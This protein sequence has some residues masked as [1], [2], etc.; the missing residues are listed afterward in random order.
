MPRGEEQTCRNAPTA[1]LV[2]DVDHQVIALVTIAVLK[3]K[4]S[5]IPQRAASPLG[6]RTAPPQQHTGH[7]HHIWKNITQTP[8]S[9]TQRRAAHPVPRAAASPGSSQPPPAV[10]SPPRPPDLAADRPCHLHIGSCCPSP[11][12][13]A[14]WSRCCS[15]WSSGAS[16]WL[17][18]SPRAKRSYSAITEETF[19]LETGL[20]EQ[21]LRKCRKQ[22]SSQHRA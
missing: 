11:P 13:S 4:A 19:K 6:S 22:P 14:S 9:P 12:L 21:R 8:L 17:S 3:H 1:H 2:G 10:L 5:Y 7:P 20:H 16:R 18:G 15:P